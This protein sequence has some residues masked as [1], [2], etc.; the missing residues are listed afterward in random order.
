MNSISPPIIQAANIPDN[1]NNIHA[2]IHTYI[3]TYIH[4]SRK[5]LKVKHL[6]CVVQI[7]DV[8]CVIK[9]L[10]LCTNVES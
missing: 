8:Y 3:H 4:R 7:K 9:L 6:Y 2:C 5:E 1:E 10:M